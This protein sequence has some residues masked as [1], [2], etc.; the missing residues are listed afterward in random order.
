[1]ATTSIYPVLMVDDVTAAADF[2][3]DHLGFTTTFA[4]DW[5]VSLRHGAWELA[6]LDAAH[7]TVP[8]RWRGAQTQGVLLNLEVDDVDA[9]Y[10]RLVEDGPLVA[11][12][13]LRSEP[14]GQRHFIV[15]GPAGAL[16]DIITPIE[17]DVSY[18]AQF[19]D[20]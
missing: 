6:V 13:P 19:T 9:V 18:A 15:E 12:L 16:V 17:P 8:D 4:A 10:R 1:M 20:A 7:A 14:F 2:F 11:V 5:Y 3:R